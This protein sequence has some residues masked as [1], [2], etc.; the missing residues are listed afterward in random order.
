M[1]DEESNK[2]NITLC[3]NEYN[4][5]YCFEALQSYTSCDPPVGE[6]NA[7]YISNLMDTEETVAAEEEVG[8]LIFYLDLFAQPSEECR[9]AFI[10]FLCLYTFGVCGANNNDYR[11]TE[12]QCMEIRD[13]ICES[14]WKKASD[15]LARAG[16]PPLPDC[17]SLDDEGLDC[18]QDTLLQCKLL[19]IVPHSCDN[20]SKTCNTAIIVS[21]YS[22]KCVA[23][24]YRGWAALLYF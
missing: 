22:Q 21:N 12:A 23:N 9:S 17:S 14:E 7:T 16:L 3:N 10:P 20:S 8:N 15:L 5:G 6:T 11:P 18:E 19:F 13:S 2:T 24:N 1:N 4:T